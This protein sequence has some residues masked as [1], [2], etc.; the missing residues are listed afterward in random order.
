MIAWPHVVGA[1]I[2][3]G[4]VLMAYLHYAEHD[5]RPLRITTLHDPPWLARGV[6]TG[7]IGAAV[8][9]SIG[10]ARAAP[11]RRRS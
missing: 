1:N 8:V 11:H 6:I 2:A 5:P 7:L 9:M 3:A 4:L 10:V